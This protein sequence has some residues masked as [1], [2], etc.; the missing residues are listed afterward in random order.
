MILIFPQLTMMVYFPLIMRVQGITSIPIE[1]KIMALMFI[2]LLPY[3][4]PRRIL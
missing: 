4:I 1:R 3:I 2:V